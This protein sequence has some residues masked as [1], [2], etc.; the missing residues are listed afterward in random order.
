MTEQTIPRFVTPLT[1]IADGGLTRIPLARI[2]GRRR[3]DTVIDYEQDP[4][5]ITLL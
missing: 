4:G 3:P 2:S 5:A 1:D